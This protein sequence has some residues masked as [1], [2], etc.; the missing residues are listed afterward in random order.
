MEAT[1]TP[2]AAANAL[3]ALAVGVP[4]TVLIPF[5]AWLF[6][7]QGAVAVVVLGVVPAYLFGSWIVRRG[8]ST[9]TLW[10]LLSS[11]LPLALAAWGILAHPADS[12]GW[13]WLSAAVLTFLAARVG[14]STSRGSS[15]T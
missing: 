10:C 11:A 3:V 6:G 15:A 14:S 9:R 7:W 1:A 5:I 13:L 4:V 12:A 2:K 8:S